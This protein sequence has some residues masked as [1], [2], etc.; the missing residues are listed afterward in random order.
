MHWISGLTSKIWYGVPKGTYYIVET[1]APK[2]YLP[3]STYVEF[4]IDEHGKITSANYNEESK[5]III[6]N[7]P[8]VTAAVEI[9]DNELAFDIIQ[10][11]H[12]SLEGEIE[13]KEILL[14]EYANDVVAGNVDYDMNASAYMRTLY[15]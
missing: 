3:I 7:K 15:K 8:E 4:S 5:K 13:L 2:G 12:R 1:I 10:Y 14:N 9:V 11:N 6:E